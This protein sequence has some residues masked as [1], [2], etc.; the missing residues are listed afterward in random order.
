MT[1]RY[2]KLI[3][4]RDALRAQ[5]QRADRQAAELRAVI[6]RDLGYLMTLTEQQIER[7]LSQ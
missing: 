1:E 2:Q 4:R 6:S 3:N 7:A 5:A